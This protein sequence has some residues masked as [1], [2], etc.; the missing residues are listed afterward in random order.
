MKKTEIYCN[1]CKK[2]NSI[3]FLSLFQTFKIILDPRRYSIL[4]LMI[5]LS[6]NGSG[7]T[8]E[9]LRDEVTTI[10]MAVRRLLE[11]N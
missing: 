11:K 1:K 10:I 9:E 7:F 5:E 6:S 2:V 3:V 8:D 4:D